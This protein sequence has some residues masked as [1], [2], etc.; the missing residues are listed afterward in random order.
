[1]VRFDAHAPGRFCWVDLSTYDVERAARFYQSVFGWDVVESDTGDGPRYLFF[2][3]DGQTVAGLGELEEPLRE[4]GIPP[5]WN[6]YVSVADADATAARVEEL[7]GTM[8][9]PVMDVSE[10]GR[11]G[12][13]QDPTGA[14]LGI[15]EP[16]G[17]FGFEVGTEANTVCWHELATR[18]LAGATAFFEG[19]FGWTT[20]INPLSPAAYRTVSLGEEELGGIIQ[21]T[22]EW[23]DLPPHWTVY[24]AVE[25]ADETTAAV[26]EAGGRVHHGPFDTPIGRLAVCADDQDAHFH[27]IALLTPA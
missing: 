14:T 15:W 25:D 26:L 22:E 4:Q 17:H 19:L 9:I 11:L 13:L 12:F 5:A 18:D 1:M 23:G 10:A 21:M 20:A 8:V 6:H 2:A 7:G 3:Q 24:F 16:D 27:V